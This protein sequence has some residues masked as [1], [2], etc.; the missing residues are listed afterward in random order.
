MG[1]IRCTSL[2]LSLALPTFFN[3]NNKV[4]VLIRLY[5]EVCMKFIYLVKEPLFLINFFSIYFH[6]VKALIFF[7]VNFV[8]K[9]FM[10]LHIHTCTVSIEIL[11]SSNLNIYNGRIIDINVRRW[12]ER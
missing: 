7:S 8:S 5:C 10:L 11:R 4:D 1:L 6:D 2:S 9:I 3:N 12:Y